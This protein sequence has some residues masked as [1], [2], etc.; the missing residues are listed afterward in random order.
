MIG[1]HGAKVVLGVEVG[2][3]IGAIFGFIEDSL[4]VL[5]PL[6]NIDARTFVFLVS[7]QIT[8]KESGGLLASK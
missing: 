5:F 7:M 2:I 6:N 3:M 8:S 1:A 4:F